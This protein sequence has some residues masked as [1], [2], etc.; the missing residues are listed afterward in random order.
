MAT[1]SDFIARHPFSHVFFVLLLR[2]V[3]CF[4]VR[5][6]TI[7]STSQHILHNFCDECQHG[8]HSDT[9]NA[10]APSKARWSDFFI[11]RNY[12][13]DPF[14]RTTHTQSV[15]F[16]TILTTLYSSFLQERCTSCFLNGMIIFWC[17]QWRFPGCDH[18]NHYSNDCSNDPTICASNKYWQGPSLNLTSPVQYIQKLDRN[19]DQQGSIQTTGCHDILWML[20]DVE[21]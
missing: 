9:S 11:L 18:L 2:F 15:S 10:S 12:E 21:Q 14:F 8:P 20:R 6:D 16:C 17:W 1:L 7:D 13:Y 19:G 3:S 4:P 5:L